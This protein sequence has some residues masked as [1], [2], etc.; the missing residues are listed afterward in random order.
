MST[1]AVSKY[2][3][4]FSKFTVKTYSADHICAIV[5]PKKRLTSSYLASRYL[6][7]WKPGPNM[8]MKGF[9]DKVKMDNLIISRW[10][11]Y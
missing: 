11:Y 3:E 6:S 7:T 8:S 9:S 1:A 10:Q 4:R 5:D 2:R